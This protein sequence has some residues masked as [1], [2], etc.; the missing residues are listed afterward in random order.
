MKNLNLLN[1]PNFGKSKTLNS[2]GK[3]D[4]EAKIIIPSKMPVKISFG[5][6]SPICKN[7]FIEITSVTIKEIR[8]NINIKNNN[9]G[10]FNNSYKNISIFLNI[11]EIS[12]L[13]I[14]VINL[15]FPFSSL[16]I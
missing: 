11:Y 2:I 9:P 13:S 10:N 5:S 3:S 12:S 15:T 14:L 7:I 16:I 6:L 4:V 1:L 8:G